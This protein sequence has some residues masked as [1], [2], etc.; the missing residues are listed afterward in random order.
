[1]PDLASHLVD[2]EGLALIGDWI[3]SLSGCP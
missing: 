2:E 3:S 1:M